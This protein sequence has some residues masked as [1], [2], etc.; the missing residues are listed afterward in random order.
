M[1]KFSEICELSRENSWILKEFWP[2]SDRN[3]SFG[4]VPRR[5]NLSTQVPD[6]RYS[7]M[8]RYGGLLLAVFAWFLS[9]T[10]QMHGHP[11]M[12]LNLFLFSRISTSRPIALNREV[13]FPFSGAF[14]VPFALADQGWTWFCRSNL[15]PYPMT[16]R[17]HDYYC[18]GQLHVCRHKFRPV[19]LLFR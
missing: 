16:E 13:G 14:E 12:L 10:F 1:L 9:P 15:T 17:A 18:S 19:W 2:N 8:P 3:S 6:S 4:S 5:S 11:E 7:A